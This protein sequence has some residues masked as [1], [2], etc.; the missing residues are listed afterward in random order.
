[1]KHHILVVED[2]ATLL[3]GFLRGLEQV[4]G[5]RATGCATVDQGVKILESDPPDLLITDINLPGRYGL[6]LLGELDARR[7]EIPVIVVTAFRAVYQSQIPDHHELTVLEKPVPLSK[8]IALVQEKLQRSPQRRRTFQL[9]DYLQLAELA[10]RSAVLTIETEAGTGTVEVVD[11]EIWSARFGDFAAADAIEALLDENSNKISASPLVREASRRN[12]WSTTQK[13][14][15]ERAKRQDE[16]ERG[17]G[18]E[19]D[20]ISEEAADPTREAFATAFNQGVRAGVQGDLETAVAA[21]KRALELR[22]GDSRARFNL[23]R[24]T[25]RLN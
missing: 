6:E 23:D 8:L 24:V 4:D 13:L 5:F 16:L 22:P 9:T 18:G 19:S 15:L 10:R 17:E 2:E 11:G 3:R 7:M 14:L 25:R 12:V 21:F 20:P 1:M